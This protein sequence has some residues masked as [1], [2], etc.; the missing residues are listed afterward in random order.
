MLGFAAFASPAYA[1]TS[2]VAPEA[3]SMDDIAGTVGGARVQ[4]RISTDFTA[5]AGSENNA[6]SLVTGLRSGGVITLT[7][8]GG[9]S[10]SASG[11][12]GGSAGGAEFGFHGR[13]I[14][15][16]GGGDRNV[17]AYG[18][19]HA[20]GIASA[21]GAPVTAIGRTANPGAVR[22]ILH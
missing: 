12:G 7:S 14:V 21:H 8:A 13:G 4:Q 20:G 2:G 10:T 18:S 3:A 1:Q 17:N 16:A 15:S 11:T 5:F 22:G 6:R 19:A 9:A